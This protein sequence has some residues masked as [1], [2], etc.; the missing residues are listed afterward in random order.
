VKILVSPEDEWRLSAYRWRVQSHGYI[1]RSERP[2]P[3]RLRWVY[4][5]REILA[6]PAGMYVDHVNRDKADNRRENLRLCTH[7]QN[8]CNCR[9]HSHNKLGIKGVYQDKRRGTFYS[10]IRVN[11]ARH[12][13]GS[14]ATAA[15]AKAAYDAAAL[16]LHGE[17]ARLA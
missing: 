17:F 6:A 4:L 13:L 12:F 2:A 7:S 1:A 15:E 3:G 10:E 14:F 8:M 16:R 5:H 9:M 11:L